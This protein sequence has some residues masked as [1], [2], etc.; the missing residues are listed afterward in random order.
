M[1]ETV[2]TP[3]EQTAQEWFDSLDLSRRFKC[4]VRHVLRMADAGRMP[5]GTKLGS[6]RRW[7][8]A[9]IEEWEAG[10]CKA[11]RTATERSR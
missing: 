5:W 3:T 8:R 9:S 6:L 1:P 4:S 2:Y 7:S 10:G 11:V